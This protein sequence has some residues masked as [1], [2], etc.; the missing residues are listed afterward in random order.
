MV[1]AFVLMLN[2][3]DIFQEKIRFIPINIAFPNYKGKAFVWSDELVDSGDEILINFEIQR[4]ILPEGADLDG[5]VTVL[6]VS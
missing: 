5:P 2:K 6:Q 4:T 3:R 1:S